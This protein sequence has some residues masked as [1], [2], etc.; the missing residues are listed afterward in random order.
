MLRISPDVHL[1]GQAL[2]EKFKRED[3]ALQSVLEAT[4]PIIDAAF[5][6]GV[7]RAFAHGQRVMKNRDLGRRTCRVCGCWE[8][9]ACNGGCSWVEADLCSACAFQPSTAQEPA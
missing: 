6:E 5:Q 2:A 8:L 3:P 9:N 4:S 1:D 7:I